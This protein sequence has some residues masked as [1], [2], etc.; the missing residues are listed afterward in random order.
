ML[1]RIAGTYKPYASCHRRSHGGD[2]TPTPPAILPCITTRPLLLQLVPGSERFSNSS[3]P[4]PSSLDL[5]PPSI[6]S[7]RSISGTPRPPPGHLLIS[8]GY[9]HTK[10]QKY[11]LAAPTASHSR[12]DLPHASE[13]LLAGISAPTETLLDRTRSPSLIPHTHSPS[14]TRTM[15]PAAAT[16]DQR[17][18]MDC[19]DETPKPTITPN[20][21]R[22][23]R[24]NPNLTAQRQ[25]IPNPLRI[26]SPLGPQ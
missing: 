9:T 21:T 19:T 16:E 8:R 26:P 3:S 25:Q 6:A 1:S 12:P 5:H 10:P 4:V 20:Q 24:L 13:T 7:I 22:Q 17:T 23:P 18:H 11:R 2:G 14:S 15:D